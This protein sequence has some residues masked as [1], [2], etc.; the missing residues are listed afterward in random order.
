MIL[1]VSKVSFVITRCHFYIYVSLQ[2]DLFGVLLGDAEAPVGCCCVKV[3]VLFIILNS[4]LCYVTWW[5]QLLQYQQN[6][7][8]KTN[9]S[10]NKG[11]HSQTIMHCNH[12]T[13]CLYTVLLPPVR[14]HPLAHSV[15]R[16]VQALTG[17]SFPKFKRG[18]LLFLRSFQKI[19]NFTDFVQHL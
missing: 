8:L 3:W 7:P 13:A 12:T 16:D 15:F 9:S 19:Q 5:L 14:T 6:A 10:R 2:H 11:Y 4:I 1:R 18:L 17:L